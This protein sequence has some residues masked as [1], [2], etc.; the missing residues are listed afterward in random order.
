MLIFDNCGIDFQILLQILESFWS[1]IIEMRNEATI[2]ENTSI[3]IPHSKELMDFLQLKYNSAMDF[4]YSDYS[5][6][7]GNIWN[8]I[9]NDTFLHAEK[10]FQVKI[11]NYISQKYIHVKFFK[12][13]ISVDSLKQQGDK[14]L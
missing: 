10:S 14:F 12:M 4:F 3:L 11:H 5:N 1:K 13:N 9:N 2:T 8:L 6:E 7:E